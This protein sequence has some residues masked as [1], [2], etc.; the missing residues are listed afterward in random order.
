LEAFRI[1]DEYSMCLI[2][3]EDLG[4]NPAIIE[5]TANMITIDK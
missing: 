3:N 4:D 5:A 2:C 1:T